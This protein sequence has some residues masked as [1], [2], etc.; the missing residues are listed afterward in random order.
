MSKR[1]DEEKEAERV[2]A[3]K[4]EGV[5]VCDLHCL[6][7][8]RKVCTAA[9]TT[10]RVTKEPAGALM[11]TPEWW[12]GDDTR[13]AILSND[14][15][16]SECHGQCEGDFRTCPLPGPNCESVGH[17]RWCAWWESKDGVRG[18]CKD[19]AYDGARRVTTRA[20]RSLCC[21]FVSRWSREEQLKEAD[22]IIAESD[23][24]YRVSCLRYGD[25][26]E[27][28]H[29]LW[30]ADADGD[31]TVGFS[32][33]ADNAWTGKLERASL[34]VDVIRST[35]RDDTLRIVEVEQ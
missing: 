12:T 35:T 29:Y 22:A 18:V 20:H 27:E 4:D 31:F 8:K 6:S 11:D 33:D 7:C 17:C 16:L 10:G 2:A 9:N 25:L 5:D 21:Q 26:G 30:T 24:R 28:T 15:H 34:L 32:P 14:G 23:R 19:P 3:L 13:A 1:K